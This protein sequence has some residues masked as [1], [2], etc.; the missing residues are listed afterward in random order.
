MRVEE[1]MLSL[2][3]FV[4]NKFQRNKIID[5]LYRKHANKMLQYAGTFFSNKSDAEN[6]VQDVFIK[7]LDKL[8][9]LEKVSKM[10][11]SQQ[12]VYLSTCV[13]NAS[14]DKL[15]QESRKLE[16]EISEAFDEEKMTADYD[17]YEFEKVEQPCITMA[18][19]NLPP[20]YRQAVL[21][22]Y[23]LSFKYEEIAEKMGISVGHVGTMLR[24]A[25]GKIKKDIVEMNQNDKER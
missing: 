15:R 6:I 13:K 21:L 8:D 4:M 7:L 16:H 12:R 1:I 11:D 25:R 10:N 14:I 5:S 20:N 19:K 23:N 3:L 9:H 17:D 2:L 24:R 22:K 18:I